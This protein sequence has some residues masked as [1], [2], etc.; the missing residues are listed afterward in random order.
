MSLHRFMAI[1]P[2]HWQVCIFI[3]A[4]RAATS[5]RAERRALPPTVHG[6][7]STAS[8]YIRGSH[9]PM[10][11]CFRGCFPVIGS[12]ALKSSISHA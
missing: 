1:A 12:D 4:G 5:G 3:V 9:G 11:A 2:P 7:R 8:R 10:L 6:L